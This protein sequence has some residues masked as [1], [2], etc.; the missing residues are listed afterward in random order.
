MANPLLCTCCTPSSPLLESRDETAGPRWFCPS[1]TVPYT[2]RDGVL[3]RL[4]AGSPWD[5]GTAGPATARAVRVDLSREGY[6]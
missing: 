6:A 3:I 2:L 5:E 1:S 4:A